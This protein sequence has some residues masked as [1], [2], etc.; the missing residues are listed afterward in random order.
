MDIIASTNRY[1]TWL[2]AQ[3]ELIPHHLGLKHSLMEESSFAMLRAAYYHW[4]LMFRDSGITGT[5]CPSAGDLHIENF[6]TWRDAEGRLVWGIND[7]DEAADLPWQNDL[8]RLIASALLALDEDMLDVKPSAIASAV[9][10]GYAKG[11][12]G[13]TKVYILAEKN[14]WLRDIAKS[15]LKHPD[16]F[17]EK[18]SAEARVDPPDAVRHILLAGLPQGAGEIVFFLRQ[19][20]LG[21]LGRPRY[22]AIA[23][24]NGGWIAREVRYVCAPAQNAFEISAESS[25]GRI[26]EKRITSPDPFRRQDQQWLLRRLAP[27][28]VKLDIADL[29]HTEDQKKL[30]AAMGRETA[31]V[32]AVSPNLDLIR[33][34]FESIKEDWFR[35]TAREFAEEIRKAR[36]VWRAR[37][38]D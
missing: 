14:E 21:S 1:E 22:A 16:A 33:S 5:S 23:T 9:L 25:T 34:E 3:T 26:L 12:A 18:L 8:L 11:L 37:R 24:W 28:C 30:L 31:A 2:G 13:K 17:F 19:A 7:Y 29:Q 10:S 6:G 32:H 15:Q 35:G 38:I 20:G 27:D 36:K 4:T